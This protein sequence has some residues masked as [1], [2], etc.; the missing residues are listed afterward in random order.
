MEEKHDKASELTPCVVSEKNWNTKKGKDST[1]D[2]CYVA[3]V[4]G[5]KAC[6]GTKQRRNS[7]EI[8]PAVVELCLTEASVS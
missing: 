7:E 4:V 8:K 5:E 2:A 3:T 1:N 6:L